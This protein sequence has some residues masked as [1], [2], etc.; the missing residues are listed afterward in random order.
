MS[1]DSIY[2]RMLNGYK[3]ILHM[4]KIYI[5][6]V[7]F[8]MGLSAFALDY[9]VFKLDNGQT[10]I[11]KEVHDNPLVIIDTWINTGSIN[12]NDENTGVSHFLEHLFFKGTSKHPAGDFDGILESK[13]AV[14]NAA[15]SKD[16][17]HYYILLPSK[18]FDLAMELHSDM[19][20]NPMIPRKELE[21]ERKVVLEEIAKNNDNPANLLYRNLN[22][23][24]YKVHP[25]KREVIGTREVIETIPREQ[26]LDYYKKWY[27]PG[28]MTTVIVGDVNTQDALA[29]VQRYFKSGNEGMQRASKNSYKMDPKPVKQLEKIDKAKIESAY[30]LIGYKGCKAENRKD[31]YALDV[32]ATIL[33][34]GKTSRLYKTVKEQK[35]LVYSINSGNS[36]LKDD[37]VLYVKADCEPQNVDKV[38]K[39]VFYEINRLKREGVDAE[40]LKKAKNII[41]RD[42]YYARESVAN[43]ANE[44]GYTMIL[45]Q[46]PEYYAHYV[47][48]IKKVTAKELQ[49][50]A[51]KYLDDNTA[52]I[53]V[54]LPDQTEVP[55][56][57]I[58]KAPKKYDAKLVSQNDKIT[59]YMLPNKATLLINHNKLNDIVAVDII[60]KGG[61][62]IEKI[63]GI[64]SVTA[65]AMLKGTKKYP[66][67]ELLQLLDENGIIISPQA[68][69][70]YFTVGLKFT[71]NEMPLA[72]NIFDEVVNK[73]TLDSYEIEKIKTDKL[74]AIKSS[75]DNPNNVAFEEFKTA[76]WQGT[77]YGYTGKIFEKTLPTI[78]KQ[79]VAEFY[80]TVFNPENMI[81]SVNGNVDDQEMIN[82]FSST[83]EGD[84]PGKKVVL[85]DYASLFK[86]FTG[87][88]IVKSPKNVEASW[89]VLGWL[90]DGVLNKKDWA[91]LQVMDSLLGSGMSSRLFTE[92]RDQQ[93]L[94]YQIG[95]S[96]SANVNKGVFAVY[97]G[98]NPK[99]AIHSRD[100]ILK[101]INRLK[102]EFVS[103][104][105]LCQAKDKL[106][107]N[108]IL[109]LETNMDKAETVGALEASDRGYE[110]MDKYPALIQSVTVQDIINVANK[111]FSEPFTLSVVAPKEVADQF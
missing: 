91:T 34:D 37:S 50:V 70:D 44:I 104:K 49:E 85:T 19:L 65:D 108:Y 25:Y 63:P 22:S 84:K 21:K 105:E 73:A 27:H 47:D 35:Q 97:I 38:K 74:N 8:F 52:A 93:G 76:M 72:L 57:R 29:K 77:P 46:D 5:L 69:S 40:E 15:T 10:V 31:S 111:Y 110:F 28:N 103:E 56:A 83:F 90:T 14:T 13:G 55:C 4:K 107:G 71:K 94:A 78:R 9:S 109:S 98:T 51:K 87:N 43:I 41:E 75:R 24:L 45:T 53:S 1:I 59:K 62:F 58:E 16:F 89:V 7:C 60:S 95:S 11:I 96:Y 3:G 80:N 18:E 86:P 81:I 100:E 92:L 23:L 61:N 39:A 54:L 12:E 2:S 82:Y 17:T 32:L 26:I 101:Q 66:K 42:T 33:G 20:L 79:D 99:T 30:V 67:Q 36:S 6:L 102:K 106:L 68:K 48:N 64:G 88:R